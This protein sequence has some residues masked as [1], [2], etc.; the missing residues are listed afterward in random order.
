MNAHR[1]ARGIAI[2]VRLVAVLSVVGLITTTVLSFVADKYSEYGELP[3]PG[4]GVIELPAG[5]VTVSFHILGYGGRGMS[6]PPLTLGIIPPAGV[7]DPKVTE[8]LGA[9]V[10]VN[11]DARR[12]V[13][14]MQVPAA[15]SYQVTAS[16]PVGGYVNPRLAFGRSGTFD[17][18]FWVFVALSIVSVD[19]A[20]AVWWF[21]RR[22]R[23]APR[24]QTADPYVP[25]DEGVRLE[26]LKTIAALKDSGAMTD[27]EFEA[28][29]RRIIQ[30]R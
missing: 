22:G 5:T 28:E 23:S 12:R 15:G 25:T 11:D 10:S 9:T 24:V 13:W 26:Q 21:Q 27:K 17:Y 18:L 20:V 7:A 2:L 6:V 8:D 14:V 30:G 1:V 19:L 4:S 29:K 3:I 16:G